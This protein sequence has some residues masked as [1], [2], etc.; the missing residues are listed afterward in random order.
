MYVIRLWLHVRIYVRFHCNMMIVYHVLTCCICIYTVVN[1]ILNIKS[2]GY[3]WHFE[4]RTKLIPFFSNNLIHFMKL[5]SLDFNSISQK[6]GEPSTVYKKSLCFERQK[7]CGVVCKITLQ[8]RHNERHSVS[9]HRHFD[10]F[11]SRL[12]GAHQ[13]KHQSSASLAFVEGIH[14]WPVDSPHKGP[15]QWRE[16]V[17]I[18]WSHHET[19]LA[20]NVMNTYMHLHVIWFF[21]H[22]N[23]TG[24]WNP[25]QPRKKK[26]IAMAAWD[27]PVALCSVWYPSET[28]YKLKSSEI[29]FGNNLFCRSQNALKFCTE[30]G[31]DTR[32]AQVLEILPREKQGTFYPT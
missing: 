19:N 20:K 25:F 28:H 30:H 24:R 1:K 16:N 32:T 6:S 31:N 26:F 27:L 9:N 11:L 3:H 4:S 18:W 10:C 12:S 7:W 22:W 21:P 29:S 13:T 2:V 23:Y 14:R 5:S 17:S 15:V 8:W